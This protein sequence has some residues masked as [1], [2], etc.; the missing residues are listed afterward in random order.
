MLYV[1]SAYTGLRESELASLT[2]ESFALNADS[3]TVTVQAAYSKR[4]RE[5]TVPLRADLARMLC[6]WLAGKPAGQRAWPGSW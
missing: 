1:L 4:R 2:P 5:D 3:P 6:D